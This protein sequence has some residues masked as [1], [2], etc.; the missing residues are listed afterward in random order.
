MRPDQPRNSPIPVILLDAGWQA[1]LT[2]DRVNLGKIVQAQLQGGHNT[3][4]V[5]HGLLKLC[6]VWKW[7]LHRADMLSGIEI[8]AGGACCA[9]AVQDIMAAASCMMKI[10]HAALRPALVS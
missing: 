10:P 5:K 8:P 6:H 3:L 4:Q 1:L 9:S 2:I 7:R